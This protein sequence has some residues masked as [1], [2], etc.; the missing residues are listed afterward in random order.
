MDAKNNFLVLDQCREGSEYNDFVGKFYHFPGKYLKLLSALVIEFV[1]YEPKRNG[2]GEYYGYGKIKKPPFKDQREE[3]FYFVEIS[4]FKPFSNPVPFD[5]EEGPRETAPHY[6]PQDAVRRIPEKDLDEICLDGG[7]QLNFKSDAHLIKV[8]GEQLIASEKVGILELIKNAYDAQA[9]YCRVR[10]EKIEGLHIIDESMYEFNEYDGPVIVVEDDGVGMTKEVI[11]VGWLRPASTLKTNVKEQIKRERQ[12]ALDS[13]TLGTYDSLTK[14]LKKESK[15][16]IPLGEKGVGRFAS[17]RLGKNLIIN[18]KIK[19]LD[20]EY[21]LKIDWDKFDCISNATV[22]LS[23]IGVS[24]TRQKITRDYGIKGSGTQMIIFGGRD[25]FH[26][27]KTALEE[28]NLSIL[29]LNSPN[30][31][32]GTKKE[33]FRAYLECPQYTDLPDSLISEE[34]EPVF[35]FDGLVTEEGILDYTLKFKPPQPAVPMPEEVIK[36][37]NFDLKKIES[38]KWKAVLSDKFRKPKCGAFFMHLDVWYRKPPWIDGPNQDLML[39]YLYHFGGISVFRDG[40]NIFPAEWGAQIDWLDLANRHIKKGKHMSYYNMIG[41]IELDQTNNLNLIDKTD[42]EGLI[43]N[44]AYNDFIN[45]T[46]AVILL[47][48]IHFQGKR[49]SYYSLTKDIIRDPKKLRAFVKQNETL[50]NNIKNNYPIEEDPH[51]I[52]AEMGE[53]S[54]RKEKLINLE[55]SL[56][57][58]G[59]SL[60]LINQQKE[61]LT[62]QAGFGLA[63]AV[64]IHEIAK[65]TSNFYYGITEA[66]KKKPFNEEKMKEIVESSASLNSELKRLSP[67]RAIK[68][69]KKV[70]FKLF[71]ALEYVLDIYKNKLEQA[72]IMAEIEDTDD[73][74]IYARY[75]QIVQ[76]F[77]NLFDNSLYW[78]D[79]EDES[80]EKIIRIKFDS[81]YRT[82]LFT[83]SGSG[84]HNAILPYLFEPGYS[85]KIP[86]S[87]LGLY[88]C[89][90]YMQSMKGDI[91]RTSSK[92]RLPEMKGAQFTLD[93]EKV[94]AEKE[95]VN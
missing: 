16:R 35:S 8:L 22:D 57:N 44:D 28:L 40:I 15:T 76:I 81:K 58:L 60:K 38:P 1:Y 62:E 17:H 42:R 86:P 48:E 74:F 9:S 27:D 5:T 80:M 41:N 55:L 24:L 30:P 13:G 87:G 51:G 84:I 45:L 56:K 71:D 72:N 64:S 75:G 50:V 19:E 85:L 2:K 61:L 32:P 89:K 65:I 63:I 7:I 54:E 70:K 11:E 14:Q 33:F 52:L 49:D 37:N 20:Y 26:W 95:E 4:D 34:F 90:H 36:D 59:D 78:L 25:G 68:S 39:D 79:T 23:S 91:Y 47:V 82:L 93:F 92:N 46:K 77:S 69:E 18:T 6:N 21:V 43:K 94:P 73:F 88:I 67:L 53:P 12:K 3:G 10:I 29:R 31:H 66:L 83:D